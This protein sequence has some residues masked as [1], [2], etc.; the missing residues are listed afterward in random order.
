MLLLNMKKINLKMCYYLYL[1]SLE[2]Q[3]LEINKKSKTPSC[4]S[5][6]SQPP[7]IFAWP[8]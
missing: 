8:T 4:H 3:L 7:F 2:R 6:Y 5:Y 1:D